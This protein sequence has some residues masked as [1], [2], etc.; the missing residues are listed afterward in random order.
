MISSFLDVFFFLL[1]KKEKLS[2]R[3]EYIE[4]FL[5]R[6]LLFWLHPL[7]YAVFLLVFSSTHSPFLSDVLSK[8]PLSRYIILLW[9]VFCVLTS[10]V[11]GRKYENLLQFNTGWLASLRTWYYFRLCFSLSCSGYDHTLTAKSCIS[12]Y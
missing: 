9:V 10:W 3:K 11:N 12:N 4:Q 2:Y 1:C 7:L 6:T 8:W 5:W